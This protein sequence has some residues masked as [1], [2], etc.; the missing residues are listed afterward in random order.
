MSRLCVEVIGILDSMY[1]LYIC[2][3][4]SWRTSLL[5]VLSLLLSFLRVFIML[6]KL[7]FE[8]SC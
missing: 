6:G 1:W 3:N 8:K 5:V 4:I 7:M 2:V